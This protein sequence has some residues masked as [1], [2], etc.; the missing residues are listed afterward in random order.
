MNGKTHGLLSRR[1][2]Q[3]EIHGKG[4]VLCTFIFI[5]AF[6]HGQ[7]TVV[8]FDDFNR[9][10]STTF[11][12]SGGTPTM[13][14][15][16]FSTIDPPANIVTWTGGDG[17][18]LQIFNTNTTANTGVNGRSFISGSL[19]SFM[20]LFKTTLNDNVADVTWTFNLRGNRSSLTGFDLG[21]GNYAPAVVLVATD[22]DFLS[23]SGYA[24]TL[25]R[26]SSTSNNGIYRLVRFQNGLVSNSNL[27]TIIESEP[28][29][30]VG[31]NY[32]SIKVV[33]SPV[34]D[35][36]KLYVRDDE[37]ATN[38]MNPFDETQ[39]SYVQAGTAIVDH[40]FTSVAMVACGFFYNHGINS[41]GPNS[42]AMFDNFGVKVAVET[43]T[44]N[45]SPTDDTYVYGRG[46]AEPNI[47]RG[48]DD[49]QFLKTYYHATQS[50]ALETY[51]KFDLSGINSNADLIENVKLKLYGLDDYGSDH[52]I[53]V[54]KMT[55]TAWD[56][57]NLSYA[58]IANTGTKTKLNS[59]TANMAVERWYEWDVTEAIK[60]AKNAGEQTLCLMLCDSVQLKKANG[61]TSVIA[62]FHSREN[63]SGNSPVLEV[64]ETNLSELLLNDIRI[65]GVSVSNFNPY[66]FTYTVSLPTGTVV[67]PEVTANADYTEAIVSI[68]PATSLNGTISE[69]T[70]KV[71]V[72]KDDQSLEYAVVFEIVPLNN[73][74]S[75]KN[76][77]VDGDDVEFFE[78]SK[79]EYICLL[80]Y[81]YNTLELPL[82]EVIAD[83]PN[84][85]MTI[86]PAHNLNG[87][88][89]ERTAKVNVTSG[90]LSES[91]EYKIVFTVLP[92]LDLYLCIGQSNMSGRG[93]INESLGDLDPVGNTY[94]LTP[95]Y[96][97]E[98]A[99][100]PLNKYSSRRKELSMQRISPAYGFANHIKNKTTAPVGLI[101]NAMGGSS[102]A[103]WTKGNSEGLY[104]AA[105]L[106]AKEAQKWGTFKAILWHQGESNSGSSSVTSYPN[107]LKAMVDNFRSDLGETDLYFV[108]GELAYWRGGGTGS[109]AFNEMIGTISTFIENSDFVSAAG[110][111]PLINES[112]PH[113]DRAS[114][115]LL[116][117]R[118]AEKV[119]EKIYGL[120][121]ET[122]IPTKKVKIYSVK[123]KI[124]I[125][126]DEPNAR[127]EIYDITG[128]KIW[129]QVIQRRSD[130]S[131]TDSGLFIVR[132]V[133]ASGVVSEKVIIE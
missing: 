102:M 100:N 111:T 93:Y 65:D 28:G 36:W 48:L 78:R 45:I 47:I 55:G 64:M 110:L 97:W 130:I 54:F 38:P 89:A 114:N 57:D 35:N 34:T 66:V 27:T 50:W 4:L 20:P 24:V 131:V 25:T 87:T 133:N 43:V 112:D 70:T 72:T 88:V 44:R 12:G 127:L 105:L 94:L 123:K 51:L 33:Y 82:I 19:S 129:S 5:V 32:A 63:I 7:S 30:V 52:T 2:L 15:N 118:Y 42:K 73:V 75:V 16:P 96:S 21:S 79:S 91:M 68:I 61:T 56:E 106:R 11:P 9:G 95:G 74:S 99:L 81:T 41:T 59:M 22:P 125:E 3:I 98:Q 13:D 119:L 117:E 71:I 18:V 113:F 53:E 58:T 122:K 1:F 8:F 60:S 67:I 115:I 132:L 84:Q 124:I 6:I 116:G 69:K 77:K 90:D 14:W 92:E 86:S 83:N 108:A 76:I 62:S 26:A 128:K 39:K 31:S 23:A 85:Q 40:N 103:H 101:V 37:H 104:E 17:R 121:S 46:G 126:Q 29:I 107:Q 120:T 109:T 10:G 80:P 49:P